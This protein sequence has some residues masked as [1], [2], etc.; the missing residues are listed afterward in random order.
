MLAAQGYEVT[1]SVATAV[2][3]EAM[4]GSSAHIVVGRK[5]AAALVSFVAEFDACIDAT[6]PYAVEITDNLKK[7]CRDT[8]VPYFR[9]LR[10][11]SH[12]AS[13]DAH[14]KEFASA[15]EAA[16]YLNK[17]EGNILLTTGS[18]ELSEYGMI[19]SVRIF[20]RVLPDVRSIE[21]CADAGILRKNIIAMWGPFSEEL[22]IALIRQFQ[23][24]FLVTKESGRE[25][26][27]PEKLSAAKKAGCDV[28]V[29]RR[30]AEEGLALSEILVK[31]GERL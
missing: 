23:I 2:G 5:T 20:A 26:G 13:K 22:N 27:Y 19:E 4:N 12:E 29:I 31:L 25:G 16:A 9:L 8:G 17:K 1:V 14:V 30:P 6:H 18:K 7:A 24:A 15:K 11:R 10:G 21:A 28:I 3:Q